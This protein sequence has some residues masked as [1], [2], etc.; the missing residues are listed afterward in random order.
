M[1]GSF[2]TSGGTPPPPPPGPP[3]PGPPPPPGAP[4]GP[5]P[6]RRPPPPAHTH[7]L[8][9]SSLRITVAGRTV[10]A[11][12]GSTTAPSQGSCSAAGSNFVGPRGAWVPGRNAIRVRVP[13]PLPVDAGRPSCASASCASSATSASASV[14]HVRWAA[15]VSLAAGVVVALSVAQFAPGQ[16]IERVRVDRPSAAL[17]ESLPD[18]RLP[19]RVRPGCVQRH[20]RAGSAHCT[21]DR[22]IPKE[23]TTPRSTG[24]SA[25]TSDPWRPSGSRR[26]PDA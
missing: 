3:P 8:Q 22:T 11:R 9:V 25:S 16:A 4:P 1:N 14:P 5:P 10:V 15:L 21:G 24:R 19:R 26:K 17:P 12:R 23:G 13:R 18:R 6:P 2:T 7:P 20:L